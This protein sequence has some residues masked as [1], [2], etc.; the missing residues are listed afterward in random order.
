MGAE[1]SLWLGGKESP[2]SAGEEGLIPDRGRHPGK[3]DGYPLQYFCL[4]RSMDRGAWPAT[5]PGV[6]KSQTRLSN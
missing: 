6:T 3:G 1:A 5:V 4:G 2:A